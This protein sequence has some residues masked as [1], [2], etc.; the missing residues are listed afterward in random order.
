MSLLRSGQT[1]LTAPSTENQKM[2]LPSFQR[3]RLF[4]ENSH[5]SGLK[6]G[7]ILVRQAKLGEGGRMER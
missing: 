5:Q 6:N 1:N 4:Q 3:D 2:Q 7:R